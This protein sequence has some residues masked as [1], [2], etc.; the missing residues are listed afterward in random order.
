MATGYF[1]LRYE[2]TTAGTVALP[3]PTLLAG[4]KAII[5]GIAFYKNG[6]NDDI[7]IYENSNLVYAERTGTATLY[8]YRLILFDYGEYL[9]YDNMTIQFDSANQLILVFYKV[10]LI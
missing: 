6:A 1:E 4:E 3:K 2:S 9:D 7:N 10:S 5:E 8:N